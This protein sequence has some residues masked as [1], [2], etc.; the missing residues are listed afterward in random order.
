MVKRYKNTSVLIVAIITMHVSY[1]LFVGYLPSEG[2]KE[3]SNVLPIIHSLVGVD[4]IRQL[5][6]LV[7]S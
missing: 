6:G 3:I 7:I 5:L 2:V 4:S 1:E